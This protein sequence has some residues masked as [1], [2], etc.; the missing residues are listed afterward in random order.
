MYVELQDQ[1]GCPTFCLQV[2][3]RGLVNNDRPLSEAKVELELQNPVGWTNKVFDFDT[4]D[5]LASRLLASVEMIYFSRKS[6]D[7]VEQF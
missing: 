6:F 2:T 3:S 4:R 1:Q 7:L 5:L